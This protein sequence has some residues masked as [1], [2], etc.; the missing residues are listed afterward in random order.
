MNHKTPFPIPSVRAGLLALAALSLAGCSF[1]PTPSPDPTRHYVLTGPTPIAVN[2]NL[3]RGTLKV[4][5][6]SVR[7]AP[8]LD[9]KAMI[10]RHGD[11]EIDYRDYARWAEPVSVGVGRML[12]TRLL[13]SNR[14]AR[15]LS[16]P[17]PFDVVRDV[18][19]AVNLLR[20][21]GQVNADGT[22]SVRFVCA[23]EITKAHE[24][25]G[26]GDLLLR[27]TFEAPETAWTEGDYAGLAR[28]L[29]E[30]VAKLAERVID[31]L[32]AE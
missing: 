29:S 5:V 11:N 21:E 8:Y 12:T 1:L 15:V 23:L 7:V 14:V 24:G 26:S 18:D 31:A 25:A 10:V 19:V 17:Y 28:G 22:A 20:C 6:R 30:A 16:Q 13:T 3:G 4:G 2:D 27:E 9:G 32:P